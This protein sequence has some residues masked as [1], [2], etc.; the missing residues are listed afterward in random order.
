M[1]NSAQHKLAIF[2]NF[3]LEPVL[4][5]YSSYILKDSFSFVDQ[6]KDIESNNNFIASFDVES[7]FTNV[8]LEEVI[9]FCID[10]LY[11]IEKHT[12]SKNNFKK[13]F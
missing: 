3:Q 13:S 8:P 10:M 12:I 1:V 6:I 9:K 2:L 11:K 4:K 5:H 7:L